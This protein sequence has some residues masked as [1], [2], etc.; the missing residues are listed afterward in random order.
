M[1]VRARLLKRYKHQNKL[2]TWPIGQ[3]IQGTGQFISELIH[4]GIA[5]SYSGEYPPKSKMKLN[6]KRLK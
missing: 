4:E 1:S 5:E 2:K 6:L 3:V